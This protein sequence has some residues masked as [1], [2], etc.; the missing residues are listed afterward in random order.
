MNK[1]IKR[2]F[3]GM[4]KSR[5]PYQIERKNPGLRDWLTRALKSRWKGLDHRTK[6]KLRRRLE[7]GGRLDPEWFV[8]APRQLSILAT[9]EAKSTTPRVRQRYARSDARKRQRQRRK[10]RERVAG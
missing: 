2:L 1:R 6:G 10:A 3:E 9:G 5:V 7:T 8:D 4:V